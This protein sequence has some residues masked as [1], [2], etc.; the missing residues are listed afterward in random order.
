MIKGEAKV[1]NFEKILSRFNALPERAVRAFEDGLTIG[2]VEIRNRIIN[3][4]ESTP[5]TGRLYTWRGAHPGEEPDYCLWIGGHLVPV[6]KRWK[7]HT[8]SSSDNPPAIDIGN[9]KQ[10]IQMDS[11][12]PGEIEVGSILSQ[13]PYPFY[14]EKGTTRMK[15]RPWLEPAVESL[16][17][18]IE[19]DTAE[20]IERAL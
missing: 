9:L 5:K 17:P 3:S 11:R 18:K 12:L 2:V 19:K 7:P 13:P 1:V 6:K 14:L 4:M 8:A 16:T 15:K 10:S 20:R